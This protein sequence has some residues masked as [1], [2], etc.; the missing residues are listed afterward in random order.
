MY[1]NVLFTGTDHLFFSS[2]ENYE[3]LVLLY[4]LNYLAMQTL[5]KFARILPKES[6]RA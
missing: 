3:N 4:Y 1:E 2:R 5:K 6:F